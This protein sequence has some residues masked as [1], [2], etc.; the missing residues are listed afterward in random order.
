MKILKVFLFESQNI[1]IVCMIMSKMNSYLFLYTVI[2]LIRKGG[3]KMNYGYIRVSSKD[4]C[5]NRQFL[6]LKQFDI[7]RKNI[8]VDKVSGKNFD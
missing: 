4:Q 6:A 2:W 5:E 7:P 8:Y 1:Y 3:I